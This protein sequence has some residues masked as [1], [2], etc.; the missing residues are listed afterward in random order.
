MLDILKEYNFWGNETIKAG[1]A[2]KDYTDKISGYLDNNLVKVILGQRR[3]G[4]SYLLRMLI[5]HLI[6]KQGVPR[7]N[8]LYINKDI[9]QLDFI[10]NSDVLLEVVNDYRAHMKPDGKVFI[11]LDEVQEIK[12]WE[13]VV[14]SF[15]QDYSSDY[16][17]FITGSNANLLSTELSTYLSGR[18][19]CFEVF[20]FSYEE[21]IGFNGL[22]RNRESFMTYLKN[23]GIPESFSLTDLEIK[24]NY[25]LSLKDSI[26][27]KDIV[28]RHSVRDVY[29]L[30]K[31]I[32]FMIDS[33]GSLF[34]I[35]SVVN[36]MRSSGYK[37][38]SDTVG[39]YIGYLK[40]AYFIMI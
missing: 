32:N 30:E 22:A 34:S 29:L 23:G 3:V 28:R 13:K 17:V 31:L 36:Y 19:I 26:V 11:F 18:Y 14:N 40:E 33:I 7:K 24:K 37:T 5:R 16:E 15:S 1:Y 12:G 10:N 35:H 27:L 21:Y 9:A 2:R 4:K 25:L 38:N 8:I 39:S 20:P 6:E